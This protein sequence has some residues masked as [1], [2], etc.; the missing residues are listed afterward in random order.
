MSNLNQSRF[1]ARIEFLMLRFQ[2]P[3]IVLT[4]LVLLSP[5]ALL[6][7]IG[8]PVVS[9]MLASGI[10][11]L[12]FLA[13]GQIAQR[14]FRGPPASG[15]LIRVACDTLPS[16]CRATF[17]REV[18]GKLKLSRMPLSS[19]QVVEVHRAVRRSWKNALDHDE[20]RRARHIAAQLAEVR[21]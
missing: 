18:A 8:G 1:A 17:D 16:A 5:L 14:L 15:A 2:A 19:S 7:F 12:T 6:P 9:P 13:Q 10:V 4:S 3:A 20:G 11:G 21:D